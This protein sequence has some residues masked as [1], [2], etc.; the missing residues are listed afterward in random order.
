MATFNVTNANDSG[1]GSFR[2]ALADANSGDLILVAASLAGATVNLQST[3]SF[4]QSYTVDA[5]AAPGFTLN[6]QDARRIATT[7]YD[8]IPVIKG[9]TFKNGKA[10]G[11]SGGAIQRGGAIFTSSSVNV[12]S[13][14]ELYNCVFENNKSDSGGA[15]NVAFNATV[16]IDGCEFRGNIGVGF[17]LSDGFSGGAITIQNKTGGEFRK[18]EIKNSV[19]ENNRGKVG[20]A[21]YCAKRSLK[22]TDCTFSDNISSDG[23]GGIF[24]DGF[25]ANASPAVVGE[26]VISRSNFYRNECSQGGGAIFAQG[27]NPD[28]IKIDNC[29]FE[30]NLSKATTTGGGA[31]RIVAGKLD[32]FNSTFKGNKSERHGGALWFDAGVN[33]T[34]INA[35][36]QL[37]NVTMFS[38]R[39]E[40]GTGTNTCEGGAIYISGG[41]SITSWNNVN[42]TF[43]SNYAETN[44]GFLGNVNQKP[45]TVTNCVMSKNTSGASSTS[46]RQQ[47]SFQISSGGGNVEFNSPTLGT[48]VVA[49]SFVGDPNYPT[50]LSPFPGNAAYGSDGIDIYMLPHPNV[51]AARDKATSGGTSRDASGYQRSSL[52]ADAGAYEYR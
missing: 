3:L 37:R 14:V 7:A 13:G 10:V 29:Y 17:P 41:A 1:A 2:Q 42:C 50:A 19:F 48:K 31:L 22:V 6:G 11:A 9:V 45:F 20:G 26:V 36:V 40:N 15:I 18:A 16:V 27:Y 39:A 23:G 30:D 4:D 33:G 52:P 49:N 28:Y 25:G 46:I 8:R 12:N 35:V 32:I 34:S 43:A 47:T 51:S 24:M 5:S 44:D 38:N 21:V